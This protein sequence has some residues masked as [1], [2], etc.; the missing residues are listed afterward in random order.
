MKVL[1]RGQYEDSDAIMNRLVLLRVAS[2][3]TAVGFVFSR[4]QTGI[5][6]EASGL[7]VRYPSC[8]DDLAVPHPSC[9]ASPPGRLH[10]VGVRAAPAAEDH[11]GLGQSAPAEVDGPSSHSRQESAFAASQHDER[12]NAAEPRQDGS[13]RC[14]RQSGASSMSMP[15]VSP[16][17]L[18]SPPSLQAP[19]W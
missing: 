15:E 5:L 10:Q 6:R 1:E 3:Y 16:E 11:G 8:G 12:G 2:C 9:H 17:R 18:S 14:R 19:N 7:S 4:L 13:S